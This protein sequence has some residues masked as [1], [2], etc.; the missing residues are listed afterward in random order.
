MGGPI[1]SSSGVQ[2]LQSMDRT[3]II[4]RAVLIA[5]LGSWAA[6]PISAQDPP[7]DRDGAGSPAVPRGLSGMGG[8]TGQIPEAPLPPSPRVPAPTAPMPGAPGAPMP[9]PAA[10]MP[11]A[12]GA[13][14]P[15]PTA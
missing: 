14:P 13:P 15:G 2:E 4:S 7:P 12:P 5:V 6:R 11:G 3:S 8:P 1:V 10:A 9:G